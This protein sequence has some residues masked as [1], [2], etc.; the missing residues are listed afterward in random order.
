MIALFQIDS[1][2][3]SSPFIVSH[4]SIS[5][6]PVM[7]HSVPPSGG[8]IEF[9]LLRNAM[10]TCSHSNPT[11]TRVATESSGESLGLLLFGCPLANRRQQALDCKEVGV[12]SSL[13]T[14]KGMK[15]LS[16]GATSA[17]KEMPARVL[18]IEGAKDCGNYDRRSWN[19]F[20]SM[21]GWRGACW[22]TCSAKKYST[23]RSLSSKHVM[24]RKREQQEGYIRVPTVEVDH[25]NPLLCYL[26]SFQKSSPVRESSG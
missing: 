8:P 25:D 4:Q 15:I 10:M 9:L 20:G 16:Q 11:T 14:K 3:F 1:L 23:R 26:S 17:A 24:H 6:F 2:P 12:N 5:L 21:K 7:F 13:L 18:A 19:R 22:F